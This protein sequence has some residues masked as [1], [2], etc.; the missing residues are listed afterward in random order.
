MSGLLCIVGSQISA[1]WKL[2]LDD[3]AILGGDACGDWHDSTSMV[4]LARHQLLNTPEARR[5]TPVVEDLECVLVWSGRL[6]ARES[7][8]AGR[9]HVT[10]AQ[11]II[12][13][14]RRWGKNCLKHLQGEYVFVLW[15]KV[16]KLLL[17]GCDVM[18][19]RTLNYYWN[20]HTLLLASRAT[21][22]LHHPL[23]SSELNELYVAHTLNIS[24]GHPPGIT[25]FKEIQRLLPGRAM[26]LHRGNLKQFCIDSIKQPPCFAS[27]KS[28]EICYEEFWQIL[29]L[30][31]KDRLRTERRV[32]TYLT[33]GLDSTTVTLSL[34]DR[35]PEVDAFTN[36]T[37]VF[38]EFDE[39]KPIEA[40]LERYPQVRWHGIN[41]DRSL[42]LQE[43]WDELPLPD[44]PL[45][46]CTIPMHLQLMQEMKSLG[47]QVI[48]EGDWGDEVFNVGLRD[49]RGRSL[50]ST[51]FS[52]LKSASNNSQ[53]KYFLS[54]YFLFPN[55]PQFL[56]HKYFS[57]NVSVVPWLNK[58][59]IESSAFQQS[60]QQKFFSRLPNRAIQTIDNYASRTVSVGYR[61]TYR[62]L[63]QF[64]GLQITAPFQ[65][66]RIVEFSLALNP[67]I[68]RSYEYYKIFLR[69]VNRGKLPDEI[70]WRPKE[71]YFNPLTYAG[72]ALGEKPLEL[73]DYLDS[74][75]ALQV[76]FDKDR[77]RNVVARYRQDFEREY[78]PYVRYK[79]QQTAQ[80]FA[81]LTFINWYKKCVAKPCR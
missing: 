41:G 64:H 3:L 73:L 11:L 36:I 42:A 81:S 35:L 56:Q 14:Y 70:L 63:A 60:L 44:D 75:P 6:D 22:L 55:L 26:V 15:D 59:Y 79:P 38:P 48:F 68:K 77:L 33:G 58:E 16:Q 51:V 52:N 45:I 20:G 65:D 9:T 39:R 30:V 37:T 54:Q 21:T 78:Q 4:S 19:G 80:L 10:D 69:Q 2:M 5:E 1:D 12:K 76:Y 23:V 71:N 74:S 8:L 13:S 29:N 46:T 25:V 32:G 50:I 28:P 40:F 34:L 17:V 47:C 18:G 49:L 43:S 7:L 62:L 24:D 66:R 53:R 27:F 57:R 67:D 31:T 61:Q 72:I